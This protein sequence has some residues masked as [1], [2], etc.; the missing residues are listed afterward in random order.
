MK[1]SWALHKK[2]EVTGLGMAEKFKGKKI[3]TGKSRE[4]YLSDKEEK[5]CI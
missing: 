3:R 5:K 1:A 2:T 4:K